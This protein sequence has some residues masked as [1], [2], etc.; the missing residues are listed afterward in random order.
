MAAPFLKT[1]THC[2]TK[3]CGKM[4][5]KRYGKSNHWLN[6]SGFWPCPHEHGYFQNQFFFLKLSENS[7][8]GENF[9]KTGVVV[10]TLQPCLKMSVCTL[11]S[12]LTAGF[13]PYTDDVIKANFAHLWQTKHVIYSASQI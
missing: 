1:M 12:F 13:T 9:Y 8:K 6:S 4:F 11:L 2:A 5:P 3:N 10:W 7:G